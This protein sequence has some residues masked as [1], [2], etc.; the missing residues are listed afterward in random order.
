MNK[1]TKKYTNAPL[2]IAEELKNSVKI[3]DF[4]PSPEAFA[5]SLRK[6]KTVPVTMKLKKDT[7]E[8]YKKFAAKKGIK[9]QSFISTILDTYAKYLLKK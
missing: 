4:L 3:Y 1:K 6:Q 2:E 5:E 8:H 9:Y 7:L